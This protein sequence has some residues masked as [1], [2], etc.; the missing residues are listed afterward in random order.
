LVFS[1]NK[2]EERRLQSRDKE[3]VI[4]ALTVFYKEEGIVERIHIPWR[5]I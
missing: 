2:K 3:H 4:F 1:W 5:D